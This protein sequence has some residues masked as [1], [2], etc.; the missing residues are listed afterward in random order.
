M[1]PL[2]IQKNLGVIADY[3]D[4]HATKGCYDLNQDNLII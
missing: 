1:T 3:L 2:I 4:K